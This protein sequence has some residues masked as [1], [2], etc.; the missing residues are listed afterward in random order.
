MNILFAIAAAYL[1]IGVWYAVK[2]SKLLMLV[3]WP[4][5]FLWSGVQ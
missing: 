3:A 5:L 4:I 2:T 1:A